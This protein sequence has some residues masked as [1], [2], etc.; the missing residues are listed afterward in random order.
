MEGQSGYALWNVC[1]R[2]LTW[3]PGNYISA[4]L[5]ELN[6]PLPFLSCSSVLF[7]PSNDHSRRFLLNYWIYTYYIHFCLFNCMRKMKRSVHI[8][9]EEK[10]CDSDFRAFKRSFREST[11][12]IESSVSQQLVSNR[13]SYSVPLLLRW[14]GRK[15]RRAATGKPEALHV[16]Q[17]SLRSDWAIFPNIRSCFH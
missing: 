5:I 6:S 1:L 7:F 17:G 14:R 8:I 10:E 3:S 4:V 16:F 11:L 13:R 2:T 15:N 12:G 9:T